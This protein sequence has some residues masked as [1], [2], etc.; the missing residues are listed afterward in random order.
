ML[1]NML[2]EA[3]EACP[4]GAAA[5]L[6]GPRVEGVPAAALAKEAVYA[7]AAV[8]AYDLHD[9][10]DF[11]PWFRGAL[12]QAR[13]PGS[14]PC[15]LPQTSRCGRP[16]T[17]CHRQRGLCCK[18]IS[19]SG[20]NSARPWKPMCTC[21]RGRSWRMRR[22]R[23][24]RCGGARPCWWAPGR[25]S[26]RPR[27]GLR[28]IAPCWASRWRPT[29]H[30]PPCERLCVPRLCLSSST[31]QNAAS[32][33]AGALGSTTLRLA[34]TCTSVKAPPTPVYQPGHRE[35]R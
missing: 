1:V 20:C 10:I 33:P 4:P 11:A 8:A 13:S 29:A 2:A 3:A 22:P 25:P 5:G 24:G 7:A 14:P 23:R 27:T 32:V 26:W 28:R 16:G 6:L 34:S 21:W 9:Y 18:C 35:L 17:L 12:L 15:A 31:L 19:R 30:N